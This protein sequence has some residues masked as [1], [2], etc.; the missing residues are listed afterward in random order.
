[1]DE[2]IEKADVGVDGI[3]DDIVVHGKD[4]SKHDDTLQR[5]MKVAKEYGQL[6]HFEKCEI[7]KADD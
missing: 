6:F 3:A 2:I 5:L 4:E 1:M 7:K